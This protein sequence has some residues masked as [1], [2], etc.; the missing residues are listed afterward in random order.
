MGMDVAVAVGA[1]VDAGIAVEVG[2]RVAV[3]GEIVEVSRGVALAAGV[4]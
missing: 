1:G 2:A 4:G 3:A